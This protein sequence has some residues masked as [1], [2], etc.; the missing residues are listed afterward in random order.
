MKLHDEIMILFSYILKNSL[1]IILYTIY[2]YYY[3]HKKYTCPPMISTNENVLKMLY[4]KNAFLCLLCKWTH[5]VCI[6]IY[7]HMQV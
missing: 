5:L 7:V 1:Y 3:I 6:N 2:L 4:L